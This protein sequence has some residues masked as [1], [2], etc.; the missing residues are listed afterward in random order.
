[1]TNYISPTTVIGKVK[2]G[3]NIYIGNNSVIGTQP[4]Y[5]GFTKKK[6]LENKFKNL[7]VDDNVVIMDLCHIDAGIKRNT[8]IGKNSM[9]M[10]G[11]YLGHDVH[12]GTNCNISPK[13]AIAGTVTLNNDVTIG[14][15]AKIHQGLKIGSCSMIGMGAVVINDVPPFVTVAGVP[16]KKI[17]VN[18]IKLER[19][20]ISQILIDHIQEVLLENSQLKKIKLS[21]KDKRYYQI[22]ERWAKKGKVT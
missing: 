14:M 22:L 7:H 15:G 3:K 18:K 8:K 13:V 21:S 9:V 17:K 2:L 16:A 10:S 12:I 5:A 4:Q 11:T 1:M 6:L 20:R 19:L